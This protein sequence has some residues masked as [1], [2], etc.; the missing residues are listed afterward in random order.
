[1]ANRINPEPGG[2]SRIL[3]NAG[4]MPNDHCYCG[5][6]GQASQYFASSGGHDSKFNSAFFRNQATWHLLEEA[7]RIH[8]A[9]MESPPPAE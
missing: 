8:L 2:I 5:C 9:T 6:G 7:V 1:M 4:F 3:K